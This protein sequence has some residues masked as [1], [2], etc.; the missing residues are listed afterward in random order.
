MQI[1]NSALN[2]LNNGYFYNGK[3]LEMTLHS[4]EYHFILKWYKLKIRIEF[5]FDMI[6]SSS[7]LDI[8]S[9]HVG[10]FNKVYIFWSLKLTCK[11]YVCERGG[12]ERY[13]KGRQRKAIPRRNKT[14]PRQNLYPPQRFCIILSYFLQKINKATQHTE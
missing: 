2:S 9:I 1:L 14:Q 13:K 10:S 3:Q 8:I 6:N 12:C 5:N 4:Y 7:S 11:P